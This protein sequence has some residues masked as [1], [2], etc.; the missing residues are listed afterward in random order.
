M[1]IY[2]WLVV[3]GLVG[4]LMVLRLRL[5]R[6]QRQQP[7]LRRAVTERDA[8]LAEVLLL[9]QQVREL[10]AAGGEAQGL[11]NGYRTALDKIDVAMQLA[12]AQSEIGRLRAAL[13]AK[14]AEVA[15][16]LAQAVAPRPTVWPD[17]RR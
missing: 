5:T 9:R 13:A 16:C 6:L 10:G 1:S 2:A 12:N 15:S 14:E 17:S 11:A 8:L 3:A 4:L 7:D